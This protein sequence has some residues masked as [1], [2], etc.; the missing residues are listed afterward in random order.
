MIEFRLFGIPV[1]VQPFHW[2]ILALFGFQWAGVGNREGLLIVALFILAGFISIL[3][4]EIGHAL[5]GRKFGAGNP[6]I[7][8]HGMGGVAIF[9]R[10]HFSRKESFLMT[11]AGPGIQIVLGLIAWL[12][13]NKVALPPTYIKTFFFFLMMVSIFWAVINLVPVWPLDGGQMM[14]AVLG[15]RRAALTHQISIGVAIALG[16]FTLASGQIF[17]ALILGFCAYQNYQA[18]QQYNNNRWH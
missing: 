13:L 10:A 16:I 3:V 18:L 1:T 7:V 6:E 2:L 14:A 17:I 8:L 12:I 11:A 15:E 4:H 9:P 5:T